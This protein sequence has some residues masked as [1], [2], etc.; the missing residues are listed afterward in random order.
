MQSR[1]LLAAYLL[2]GKWFRDKTWDKERLLYPLAAIIACIALY[3][4]MRE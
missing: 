1:F 3:W 4:K 2:I